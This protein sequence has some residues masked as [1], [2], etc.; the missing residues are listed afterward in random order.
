VGATLKTG[1]PDLVRAFD[2][3][4]KLSIQTLPNTHAI[5]KL[6]NFRLAEFLKSKKLI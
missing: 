6:R 4:G 5:F 1:I 3:V 2:D